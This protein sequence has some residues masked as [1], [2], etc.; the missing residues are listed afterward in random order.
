[1]SF[2]EINFS[3]NSSEEATNLQ[4]STEEVPRFTMLKN[5]QIDDADKHTL[6][7]IGEGKQQPDGVFGIGESVIMSLENLNRQGND[8]LEP[9][10]CIINNTSPFTLNCDTSKHSIKTSP[11]ALHL[12]SGTK[13]ESNGKKRLLQILMQDA[14]STDEFSFYSSS[15][16]RYIKTSSGLSGG[17]IAGIVIACVV[18]LV[19]ASIAAIMLRK[20]SAPID[21]STVV[22]L[23]S[24][25]NL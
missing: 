16:N 25:D 14:N 11:H 17:A 9:Y 13:E 6:R 19:A 18:V 3:G 21:N 20:P 12:S 2:E 22:G 7:I 5:G 1:M 15:N 8:T 23:K 10:E 24:T 4:Q